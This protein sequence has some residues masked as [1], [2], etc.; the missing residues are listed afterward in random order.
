MNDSKIGQLI[1]QLRKEKGLTQQQLASQ[2]NVTN[3]AVSKWECGN[4]APDVSLWEKLSAILGADLL[5]LLQGE[6]NPNVPDVGK[7]DR[8]RFYVCKACGN[9]LTSTSNAAIS[10]C[11][12]RLSPL[13]PANENPE[14][15]I[16]VKKMD[17]EYYVSMKHDMSKTHYIAFAAYVSD[18]RIWFQRFY[19]EQSPGFLIPVIRKKG[20][21]YL[22]C[23]KHGL[24][25]YPLTIGRKISNF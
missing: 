24:F 1:L 15:E 19:P 4:G 21:L 10:C 9:I 2:L 8:I 11:G 14:H 25:K 3:K 23:I 7:I 12:R 20:T 5:K 17:I 22:Y 6:L 13:V 18:D 16:S